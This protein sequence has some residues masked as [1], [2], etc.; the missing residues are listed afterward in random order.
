MQNGLRLPWNS[1]LPR[2][3]SLMTTTTK[4]EKLRGHICKSQLRF[5][6]FSC[7]FGSPP[8]SERACGAERAATATHISRWHHWAITRAD[9]PVWKNGKWEGSHTERERSGSEKSRGSIKTRRESPIICSDLIWSSLGTV[10]LH[11]SWNLADLCLKNELKL[12]KKGSKSSIQPLMNIS[13]QVFTW[14]SAATCLTVRTC[15]TLSLLECFL[16]L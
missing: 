10:F 2:S 15:V 6:N 13:I 5:S 7:V 1:K 3:Q 16:T 4:A 11:S 9:T 14:S 8:S 12:E